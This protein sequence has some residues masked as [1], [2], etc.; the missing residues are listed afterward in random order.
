MEGDIYFVT[1]YKFVA[2]VTAIELVQQ[3]EYTDIDLPEAINSV[4]NDN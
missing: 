2:V 3:T 1:K 4:E